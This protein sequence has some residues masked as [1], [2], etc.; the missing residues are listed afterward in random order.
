M[1]TVK[2]KLSPG[3]T[4]CEQLGHAG[5]RNSFGRWFSEWTKRAV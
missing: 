4:C 3:G 5:P 1:Y 2:T